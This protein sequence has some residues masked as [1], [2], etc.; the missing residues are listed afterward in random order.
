MSLTTRPIGCYVAELLAANGIDTVFGIPGV[1]TLELYRGLAHETRLRH[2]LTRHEQ[3]A[4]FAADGYARASGRP[5]AAF[6]ISGPGLTNALTAIGQAYSDSVPMLIVA[7]TPARAS[8]GKRW[9]VLHELADQHTVM[10]GVLD[11]T[12]TAGSADDVRDFLQAVF[13]AFRTGCPRPAYLGIPLDLLAE[14]T[15]LPA[16]PFAVPKTTAAPAGTALEQAAALLNGAR[17]PVIIA[18]GGARGAAAQIRQLI[19]RLDGYLATTAAGKGVLPE[20]HRCNLGCSLPYEV[21]QQLLLQADVVLAVGTQMTETDVYTSHRLPLAGKLIRI[22]IDAERND[23]YPAAVSIQ[24]DARAALAE[25]SGRV[26]P[27]TGWC[28]EAGDAA[29]HRSRIDA[30]LDPAAQRLRGALA[31]IRA[32]LPP[33][34]ALFTDM[35]QIAYLGNYAFATDAPGLWHHPS[36]YGTLGYAFPA[37]VGAKLAMPQRAV[38]ALAGDFGF[39]FTLSEL[40]TAVESGISLPVIVWNNAALGQI[41]DDMLATGIPPIGV[42]ARN[43]DFVAL[44]QAY[45]ARA[46]KVDSGAQLSASITAAL[47]HAGPTLIEVDGA[48]FA[49]D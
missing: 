43:P 5:A 35:A 10:R 3:G 22:D 38:A 7:S 4:G 13:D 8:L 9:G 44:A 16:E 1:H 34:A 23:L 27:R 19:E 40:A 21:T 2:I 30:Q 20:A 48:R 18:G 26:R 49:V 33:D 47:G 37:A 42:V 41:K 24:A 12:C 14:S 36:G 46:V 11:L 39:Q 45:G 32:A 17:R 31:A 29:M 15:N 28:T 25:L 6:V